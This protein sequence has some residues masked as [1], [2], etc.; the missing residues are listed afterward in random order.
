MSI[1]FKEGIKFILMESN[2]NKNKIILDEDEEEVVIVKMK[3]S[4]PPKVS[5]P[6]EKL[7]KTNETRPKI[8]QTTL[9]Q[10]V[11]KP[12]SQPPQKLQ[13][14]ELAQKLKSLLK[15][16]NNKIGGMNRP[17]QEIIK[18]ETKPHSRPIDQS[19][20]KPQNNDYLNRKRVAER[21]DDSDDSSY[22][23]EEE[24][25][26]SDYDSKDEEEESDSSSSSSSSSSSIRHK[27]KPIKKDS[28]HKRETQKKEPI[29]RA[30]TERKPDQKKSKVSFK[31][32][33]SLVQALLK[34]WWYAID[35]EWYKKGV[36]VDEELRRR[37]LRSVEVR[38]WKIE[39]NLLDG[40][41]KCV[42]LLGTPLV[43]VDCDEQSHD[44]RNKENC[45]SY[46]NFMKKD[47][48]E[49]AKLLVKALENQ[50]GSLENQL[51]PYSDKCKRLC[52]DL[53]KEL[54]EIKKEF[55]L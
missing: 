7:I 20:R 14:S 41:K 39:S 55:E 25:E 10:V 2:L 5:N 45:P 54:S 11:A 24:E 42:E 30:D 50:L 43:Y 33:E 12:I 46:N 8:V 47:K 9:H 3:Q 31:T 16:D 37:S 4:S 17:K 53:K 13:N 40:K 26:D 38:N 29:K 15:N 28:N 32:K 35:V 51:N 48:A 36:N 19:A 18:S 1:V 27:S 22:D 52:I 44:L 21:V 34:R 6:T 49:L 23:A